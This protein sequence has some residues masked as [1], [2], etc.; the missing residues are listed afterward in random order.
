M[1]CLKDGKIQRLEPQWVEMTEV[2]SWD[3]RGGVRGSL[4]NPNF[5]GLLSDGSSQWVSWGQ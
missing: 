3:M 1:R 4:S 2:P 5:G